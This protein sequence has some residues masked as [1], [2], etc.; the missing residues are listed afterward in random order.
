MPVVADFVQIVGDAPISLG[1]TNRLV[2]RSFST[3]GRL[4][5]AGAIVILN[6][7]HLTFAS[8]SPVV[9]INNS[10]AG[11]IHPYPE[12][13]DADR[14]N[15]ASHWHTQIFAVS[16]SQLNNGDNELQVE[17]VTFPNPGNPGNL[18]DDYEVKNV[19]CFFHKEV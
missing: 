12:L 18:F 9:K 8:T 15:A 6:V 11:Y 5:S 13:N 16:G 14:N 10:P 17:A 1:D 7:R 4:A 2:E 3:A 19:V